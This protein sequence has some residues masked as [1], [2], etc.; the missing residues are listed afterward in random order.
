MDFS[1]TKTAQSP[2]PLRSLAKA[3][4]LRADGFAVARSAKLWSFTLWVEQR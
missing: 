3:S 4:L 2:I 1:T